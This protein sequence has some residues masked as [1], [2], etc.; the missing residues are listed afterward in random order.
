MAKILG[1]DL[2]TNSIGWAIVDDLENE[3]LDVGVRIFP[4]GVISKTI[5]YGD[6]E[7]SKNAKRRNSRQLRKQYYRKRIRKIKLLRTLINF[8]MCPLEH[9]ELDVWSKWDKQKKKEGRMAPELFLPKSHSYNLWLK[10]DPYKLRNRALREDLT[11]LEFGRVLYHLIQ[12]RGFLSNRKGKD[13]GAIY[14]GKE[15][16]KGIDATLKELQD[17]TLG[18]YLFHI[19]PKDGEPYKIIQDEDGNELRVRSRYTLRDMY[20]AE[21]EAIWNRQSK[22]L[23]LETV[24]CLSEKTRFLNGSIENKRNAKKIEHLQLTKGTENV[25]IKYISDE[26]SKDDKKKILLKVTTKL[27]LK[28]FLAGKIEKDEEENL[29]FKSNESVLFWQRP[30]KSQ[31]KLL[32]KCRFE[33]DLKDEFGKFIQ[34]G[35]TPCH[36]SHPLFEQFRAYKFIN[37]IEYGKKQRLEESQ[38]LEVLELIN[39]KDTNFK[40]SEIQKK[41]KLEYETFNYDKDSSVSGSYTTKNLNSVFPKSILEKE[42]VVKVNGEDVIEYGIDRI[43]HLFHYCEDNDILIKILQNDYNLEEDKI[44]KIAKINL[45][46]GYSS[47][48]LKAI[49]NI[50][51]YLKEGKR[52]SDAVILGGVRNAFGKRWKYFANEYEELK[53]NILKIN[54][55]KTNKEGD[56]IEKI[57]RYLIDKKYGF[58][59]SDISFKKLYHHSQE[60]EIKKQFNKIGDI[61]NLRNPIVQQGVNEVKRIVNELIVQHGKFDQIRV[62]LGRDLK[63]GKTKRQE[64]TNRISQNTTKNENA[65]QLLTEYGLSHG[66]E[67][68]QKVLLYQELQEKGILPVCPY[69]NKTINISDVLGRGNKIQIEHIIP[70]SVSLDDSFANKTLCDSK[71]NGLKGERTPYEF[72]QLNKDVNLW[73]GAKSWEEIERRAFKVLPYQKA[74]RFVSQTKF[75]K[76]TFIERQLNDTRY[77]S[78]KTAGILS[79]VC[80]DVRVMPGSLTAELRRLWGLNNILQPAF[81]I[82]IP[83]LYIDAERH[84]PHYV[85]FDK[86][87][88]PISSQ[89]IF[90]AKPDLLQNETTLFGNVDKGLFKSKEQY[91]KFQIETPDLLHGEYWTKLKLSNPKNIVRV[92]KEKPE[93]SEKEIVV[94]GKIEKE[95]F[96]TE[97]LNMIN[98]VGNEN[99]TYWAKLTILNK[100]FKKPTKE[101]QPKKNGKQIL[102]YGEVKEKVFSSYVYQC[103][104]NQE[105]GK[106]WLIIDIDV[107]NVLF[108]KAMNEKPL[109]NDYQIVIQGTTNNENVFV[110]DMD[111]QHHFNMDE[112]QGKYYVLF[113]IISKVE[114]FYPVKTQE[115]K[116]EDGQTLVEGT[117]WVDKYTGEIKFDPKK[118]RED[119]RHHAIDAIVIA[120]TKEK[121]FQELSKHN[122]SSE[123][124]KRGNEYEKEHLNFIEPWTGFHTDA[125][126]VVN[127]ILISFK[128]NK[129]ILTEVRKKI[130]KNGKTYLSVGDSVR[131]QLHMENVYGKRTPP[132]GKEGFHRRESVESLVSEKQINKIV[133]TTIR[134]IIINA[135]KEEIPIYKEIESLAKQ[136]KS[137]K[138]NDFEEVSLNEKIIEL[139]LQIKQLY[140]L[141]NKK[142][143]PVPIKKVRVSQEIGNAQQL[144]PTIKQYVN[145]RKNHHIV[146][147]KDENGELKD[148]ITNF[149]NVVERVKHKDKIYKLPEDKY[150]EPELKELVLTLQENDMFLLGLS[151]EE[152]NDNFEN[153]SF[154]SSYLYRVQKISDGDFSF[155][156]HLAST[157]TNKNEEIRVASMKKYQEINPIKVKI[158][159]QGKIQIT[160]KD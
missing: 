34:K 4:E 100:T 45:K 120:L 76:N 144:K 70:R 86:D 52:E 96:K 78:K 155:R 50:L 5:G 127:G 159:L 77:I 97:G 28:E 108:D 19:L 87:K 119:H 106:Y 129:N 22:H 63:N 105:D 126:K 123:N 103:D 122:A 133:D 38:R 2:G 149:W 25:E 16:V 3:I 30:L 59:E 110:S 82:D 104:T 8:E 74:K 21:F 33:P 39:S 57:K 148:S 83:N 26:L 112:G 142:G 32:A 94:R 160:G 31:K 55:D 58:V 10:Q 95:K 135:R 132:E 47:F 141:P 89:R 128:Q 136:L 13:D 109:A 85:V 107:E 154:L 64:L 93:T 139:R 42:F 72:Y 6:K 115:Q 147:Y 17:S 37:N 118:N 90:N 124:K 24:E 54:Y 56:S 36:L 145:P 130:V 15:N 53:N 49:K 91:V 79:Q 29:K 66:R 99:G 131:G 114:G 27:P 134:K 12:R 84:I 150:V 68:I 138:L 80:D 117:V 9:N 151:N 44:D 41:L 156:H 14:K 158:D 92:F 60:V 143:E 146:I 75:D 46:E 67:N 1:L 116:L 81:T 152:Y 23:G 65:K 113:D 153:S 35:K 88:N 137:S 98:A 69:T 73:G 102:L 61:E 111:S 48:S 40:F 140:T 157:V 20:V 11:L 51:P 101:D 125:Q 71:F 121:Y 7:E 62:E 18:N 43:W